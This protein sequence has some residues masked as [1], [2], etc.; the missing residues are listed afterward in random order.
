MGHTARHQ[1]DDINS[2]THGKKNNSESELFYRTEN[3]NDEREKFKV[4]SEKICLTR[5]LCTNFIS[6]NFNLILPAAGRTETETQYVKADVFIR[7]TNKD[8]N[9][10]R[11]H[12]LVLS[13]LFAHS[14]R[15]CLCSRIY[16]LSTLHSTHRYF[17]RD[18]CV[19]VYT[20]T[21]WA[22]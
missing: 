12:I 7:T 20:K 16:F 18:V 8:N 22:L 4:N 19:C 11:T 21:K 5:I 15:L 1:L 13:Y 2:N 3:E 6:V 10:N 9:E 14:N 17:E